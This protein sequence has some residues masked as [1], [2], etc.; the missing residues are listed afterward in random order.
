[1]KPVIYAETLIAILVLC[2]IYSC[3]TSK[4]MAM[5]CPDPANN[6]ISK[7]SVPHRRN[8]QKIFI[9]S[10]LGKKGSYNLNKHTEQFKKNKNEPERT[11]DEQKQKQGNLWSTQSEKISP[12]NKTEYE[13]NLYASV[14]NS[15]ISANELYLL[16]NSTKDEIEDFT[17]DAGNYE[18]VSPILINSNLSSE[19]EY[20]VAKKSNQ[21][22]QD[23]AH[24]KEEDAW[25]WATIALIG[26]A[27][28]VVG[29]FSSGEIAASAGLAALLAG[30]VVLL[31]SNGKHWYKWL[32]IAG[33]IIGAIVL[34][35]AL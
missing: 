29:I 24:Y 5:P 22:L 1:M 6:Y 4:K 9:A 14:E 32:A 2:F 25:A 7:H 28:G 26:F 13:T 16:N 17:F 30:S 27:V 3:A 31:S 33:I 35:V 8:N 15:D 11:K 12:F 21:E 20:I 34:V 10:Q 23:N 19:A 18:R